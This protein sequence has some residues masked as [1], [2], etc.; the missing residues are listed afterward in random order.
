MLILRNEIDLIESSLLLKQ[1]SAKIDTIRPN[2]YTLA[3]DCFEPVVNINM[4]ML[5]SDVVG[6]AISKSN[7]S[8]GNQQPKLSAINEATSIC[9]SINAE[10]LS[11]VPVN[12][13]QANASPLHMADHRGLAKRA[14]LL[15][16]NDEFRS[17]LFVYPK[18]LKYDTQ[19]TFSRARNILVR[20]ELRDDDSAINEIFA[21]SSS[22]ALK[23][24]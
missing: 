23:V 4:S 11:S 18:A 8:Q 6:T 5:A 3:V 7:S 22:S 12:G 20:T 17:F 24:T 13:K 1:P 21:N 16:S 10:A 19:K 14:E 2:E 9:N 15:R